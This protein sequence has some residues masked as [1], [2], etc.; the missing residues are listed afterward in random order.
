[1]S[2]A[3]QMGRLLSNEILMFRGA[4]SVISL[5]GNTQELAMVRGRAAPRCQ[6]THAR[7][8]ASVGTLGG[9]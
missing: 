6:R 1:M 5:E 7:L 9:L 2:V 4:E 3:V 8:Y